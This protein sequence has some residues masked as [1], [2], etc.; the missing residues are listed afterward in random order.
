MK[1]LLRVIAAV[2]GLGVVAA[3]IGI[4]LLAPRYTGDI[5]FRC[6]VDLQLARLS[7]TVL[8]P[9]ER[10]VKID[11]IQMTKDA[12]ESEKKREEFFRELDKT[13]DYFF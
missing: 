2:V 5:E 7:S 12:C 4:A 8:K 6:K 13:L 9:F 1:K 11:R 3:V 10:K